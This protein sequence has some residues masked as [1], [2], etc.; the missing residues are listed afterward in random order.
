MQKAAKLIIAAVAAFSA[1]ACANSEQASTG[2]QTG[3]N[4]TSAAPTSAS[5]PASSNANTAVECT[6][7][8]IKV[9]GAF[10]AKPNIT[11][12][13]ACSPPRTLLSKDLSP[14]TGPEVKA[15]STMLTNYHLVTWS[16]KT[17]KDSSFERGEPFPLENV[18]QAQVID[19]WNEGLIGIKEGGRRL[20]IV[21]PDKGY[22]QGGRGIAP[23]ETLV[24]VIDAVKVT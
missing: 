21:P 24:F 10:G 7:D 13:D 5:A 22:G 3:G 15:G 14:G 19:G 12:P 17:V 8:D 18:G 23:N 1:T 11:V 4:S 9:E 2:G 20:L 6:A 16:E